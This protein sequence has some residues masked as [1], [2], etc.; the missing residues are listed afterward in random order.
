MISC[1]MGRCI[2]PEAN[3]SKKGRKKEQSGHLCPITHSRFA[4]VN[5]FHQQKASVSIA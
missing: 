1:A 3:R 2:K 5:L 4:S